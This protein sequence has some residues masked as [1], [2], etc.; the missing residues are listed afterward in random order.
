MSI[1]IKSGAKVLYQWE[2][3]V[4]LTASTPCDILRI[5]REDDR[6]TDDLYP[7]ISGSTGTALI[8]DRMLT[9]SGYLHVSRIDHAD[10]SERVLETVRI[11]VRH[12]A[13]PQNTASSTKEVGDMQALRMQMAALERAAREGKFDGKDGITPHIGENGNWF[14]GDVDF[15]IR[16][17]GEKGDKGDPGDVPHIGENGNWFVGDI[18]TGVKARNVDVSLYADDLYT[19]GVLVTDDLESFVMTGGVREDGK[20]QIV[21]S[22]GVAYIKG[23]RRWLNTSRRTYDV[24]DTDR[25]QAQYLRLNEATGEIGLAIWHDVT[26]NG[27]LDNGGEIVDEFTGE[28]IPKRS[29]GYYDVILCIVTIPA[30][31]TEV[32]P[33]MIRD[34]RGDER[35][36]GFVRSKVDGGAKALT[37]HNVSETAHNDI[38]LLLSGLTERLNAIADSDDT[39]LDQLSE[40]VA[41]IK[42]NKTLIESVTTSKVNVADIVDNLTTNVSDQPLSAKMGVELRRLIRTVENSANNAMSQASSAQS[43]ASSAMN[44]ASSAEEIASS[45]MNHASSAEEIASSAMQRASSAEQMASAAQ[46]EIEKLKENGV[47]GGGAGTSVEE[48]HIGAD[49]PTDGEKLWIDLDDDGD[50]LTAEDVKNALGYTPANAEAVGELSEAIADKLSINQGAANVGK[51][52]V[53]GADGNLTLTDMPEGGASGDVTGVLDDSKNILLTGNLADGTYT[54]KWKVVDENGEA[55]Y[56]DAGA[57]EVSSI[58]TYTVTQN[59]TEVTSD[60]SVT[61]VRN[62]ESI[63]VNLTANDGYNLKSITVTMG[64]TDITSTAVSGSKVTI[65]SVTGDVVITAVAEEIKVIEPV[66]VDIALTDGLRLGSDG[67]D[68]TQAGYC[69]TEDINLSNIP[70]PCT[71]QLT[72][73]KWLVFDGESNAMIRVYA[74]KAD[75]TKLISDVIKENVGGSYF[76][77]VDNSDIGNDVVVTVTSNDVGYIRFSGQW[78]HTGASDS[79]NSFAAANTKATLTYTPES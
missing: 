32:T 8:P 76:T 54:L 69:A 47:P 62:G 21:T 43:M 30:G 77:V 36:C 64:G 73:A 52:L 7:V 41:Y 10:G 9:E 19:S 24:R 45:A 74:K 27:D 37:E 39:T 25:V 5:S 55:S 28:V 34:L 53:V 46:T 68:R 71:I 67:T 35:Y 29:G 70:K 40:I 72:K 22:P 48:I 6:V 56:V 4:A 23:V 78:T 42:A 1:A 57:L 13:K 31:A 2:R 79:N 65:A 18:D 12:A 49:E 11:L 20:P 66:T 50:G 60:Y 63:T 58:V 3:G 75:G 44:H 14:A 26:I 16:A 51:I 15:G 38:R 59:L 17:Q 61:A 33:D